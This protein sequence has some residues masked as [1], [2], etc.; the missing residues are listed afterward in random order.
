MEDNWSNQ[1]TFHCNTCMFYVPKDESA[2][3]RCRRH[4]PD[5]SGWPV[6]FDSDWC[7]DHKMASDTNSIEF[8]VEAEEED[9]EGDD[10]DEG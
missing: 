9:E 10:D 3:G 4:S 5:N 6:V 1:I 7:G 8:Y 2:I